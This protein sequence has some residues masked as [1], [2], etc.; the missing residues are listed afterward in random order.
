MPAL[1]QPN[2]TISDAGHPPSV[3]ACKRPL[4]DVHRPELV[5]AKLPVGEV[6]SPNR[7]G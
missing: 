1:R 5:A 6:G 7:V 2:C 4:G 3:W